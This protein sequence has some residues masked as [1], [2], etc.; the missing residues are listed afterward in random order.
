MFFLMFESQ[1]D[2]FFIAYSKSNQ[3]KV[4]KNSEFSS[5]V[6]SICPNMMVWLGSSID[7]NWVLLNL[8]SLLNTP[9]KLLNILLRIL[10]TKIMS[11]YQFLCVLSCF[12]P[13]WLFVTLWTIALQAPL[14]MGFLR[15]E[16]WSGLPCPT[17]GHLTHPGIEST[18]L[19]SPA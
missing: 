5:L 2:L 11:V 17:P 15:Q 3:T 18:S 12:C 1:K 19:M 7:S 6:F 14:S 4:F 13:I 8:G 9:Q 10:Y 16:Y